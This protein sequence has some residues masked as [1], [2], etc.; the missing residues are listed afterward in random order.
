MTVEKDF[1]QPPGG[2]LIC[3]DGQTAVVRIKGGVV[4]ASCTSPPSGVALQRGGNYSAD[5]K[6]WLVAL[7]K[8][9]EFRQFGQLT[10]EEEAIFEARA[11]EYRARD[12]SL[13]RVEFRP[14]A[15]DQ[16]GGGQTLTA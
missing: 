7:V 15:L 2:K 4:T 1:P 8:S 13:V 14:P 16:R 6:R 3:E 5:F 9:E 10:A 11:Y 12:G